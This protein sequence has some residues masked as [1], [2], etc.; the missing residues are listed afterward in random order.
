MTYTLCLVTTVI[1]VAIY[2]VTTT[3]TISVESTEKEKK[4]KLLSHGLSLTSSFLLL[5]CF[6]A[7]SGVS[8]TTADLD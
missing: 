5:L 1:S 8:V 3:N 2:Y 4:C 6:H 7:I